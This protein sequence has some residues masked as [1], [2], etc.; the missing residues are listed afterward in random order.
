MI[1]NADSRSKCKEAENR[2][3]LEFVSAAQS[4]EFDDES[5]LFDD[6]SLPFDQPYRGRRRPSRREE[7][8]DD[9]HPF[10]A[11]HGI[12]A[13]INGSEAHVYDSQLPGADPAGPFI[14]GEPNSFQLP[15]FD[16]TVKVFA[17]G[18]W[19]ERKLVAVTVN[20]T[21]PSKVSP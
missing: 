19:H 4:L 12:A 10:P 21:L 6:A 16:D 7:I 11:S 3:A 8:I 17:F 2:F 15:K 20:G 14:T 9:V 18:E 13:P 5:D 1:I